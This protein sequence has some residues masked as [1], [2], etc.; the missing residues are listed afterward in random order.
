MSEELKIVATYK[1]FEIHLRE[2]E[3]CAEQNEYLI[4]TRDRFHKGDLIGRLLYYKH[5][6][7]WCLFPAEA[8][9]WSDGCLQDI[10]SFMKKLHGEYIERVKR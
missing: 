9:V 2:N 8:T 6:K 7:Q 3:S 4:L 10:Q 5:W 1:F